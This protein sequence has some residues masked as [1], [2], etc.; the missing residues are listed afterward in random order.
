MRENR[1][2]VISGNV[3]RHGQG[4]GEWKRYVASPGQRHK[5]SKSDKDSLPGLTDLGVRRCDWLL[6]FENNIHD[7][8]ILLI[9][10]CGKVR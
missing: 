8:I 4:R 10:V 2:L 9:T 3:L 1:V 5:G 6:A 7:C